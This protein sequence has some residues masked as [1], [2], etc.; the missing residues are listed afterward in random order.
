[1]TI[2][3]DWGT[4]VDL[5]AIEV[6]EKVNDTLPNLPEE[7]KPPRIVKYDP[8]SS[9]I[10]YLNLTAGGRMSALTLRHYAENTLIYQLQRI[11]GV[12]S[13]DIWGGDEREIQ[14]L[15]DRSRLEATGIALEHVQ[16]AVQRA[17]V[18]KVGGHLESG[19]TDYVIR[20]VGELRSLHD[21]AMIRLDTKGAMPVYL[22]EV[23]EV[24]DGIK[25]VLS[26]TRVNR[27]PGIVLAIRKQSGANTVQVSDL[28]QAEM[29]RLRERLPQGMV[30]NLMFERARFIRLSIA[31]VEQSAVLGGC[32]AILVLLF[33][34]RSLR[35]TVIIALSIPL[36]VMATFI[37]LFQAHI[38]LNWMSL[39]GLALGIGM[40][41]DNAVVVLENI[42]RHRQEGA[43]SRRAA[44]VG[45][46]EVGMAIG[47][48]EGSEIWAPLGCVVIGG[49]SVTTF[50]TLLFIPA[51]YSVIEERRARHLAPAV[52]AVPPMET[53]AVI[54]E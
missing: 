5:A 34:L 30:L 21:I 3:F 20:P 4:N 37:L 6:R 31:Q 36:A 35:P 47:I 12:A 45:S 18:T 23:A 8:A 53:E 38:S 44:V 28:L 32:I 1:V 29:P 22:K 51:L 10:M 54:A 24:R 2:D 19:R 17:N 33:F 27:E 25:K 26:T 13:V 14:V 41:V 46:Q 40:L 43:E 11:S 39:S 7:I 9:P 15:V 48:G 52:H 50:F 49:L 42:F 16:E